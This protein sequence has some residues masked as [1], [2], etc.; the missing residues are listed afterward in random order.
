MATLFLRMLSSGL[1]A[2]LPV[3]AAVAWFA[4]QGRRDRTRAIWIG[5]AL[6]IVLTWPASSFFAASL[7]QGQWEAALA[8]VGAL[9]ALWVLLRPWAIPAIALVDIAIVVVVRQAIIPAGVL[10][11][12]L[13]M[14]ASAGTFQVLGAL[15]LSLGLAALWLV[16]ARTLP[17][18][19]L[20]TATAT[21]A[22]LFIAQT[23]FY[24]FHRAAEL[25][26]TPSASTLEALTEPYGPDGLYGP[27]I[28]ASIAA[29]AFIA[30]VLSAWRA[31]T[32]RRPVAVAAAAIVA[33][34]TAGIGAWRA[35]RPVPPPA[36]A[37]SADAAAN[38]AI[39]EILAAPH[40]LYRTSRVDANY[41]RL[42]ITALDAPG[43]RMVAS[44]LGCDRISFGGGAGICLHA[45]R[46]VTTTFEAILF[47]GALRKS[48]AIQVQGEPSRTRVSSDGRFGAFTVFLA[49]LPHGYTMTGFSTAT[50]IVNMATGDVLGNLESFT[51]F[52]DGRPFKA[53][54]FNFW[55]VTFARDSNTFYATLQTG[56]VIFLVRGDVSQKTLTVLREGIECP[57]LS[58][59]G[60]LIAFKQRLA[61]NPVQ[62]RLGVLDLSTMKDQPI[63]SETRSIDDQVEWLD[64]TH[65]LYAIERPGQ[66]IRDVWMAPIAGDAPA[67]L[68]LPEAESPIVVGASSASAV[69]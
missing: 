62:W 2:L 45:D 10:R 59:D 29:A 15:A 32:R 4:A 40:I 28:S 35:G 67:R 20:R 44:P 63:A 38:A 37:E 57:S 11:A 50:V 46:G 53:A 13:G 66:P 12:T 16:F 39:A 48:K 26:W 43:K 64:A 60:R 36:V 18:R 8:A 56:G 47:D 49:G 58:P 19:A 6:G 5:G 3:A 68:F 51:T 30:G 55:G 33:I 69:Q 17:A 14:P 31:G 7:R 9:A 54:D 41:G 52:R 25:G 1:Q 42:A 24:A 34:C 22:A 21:F 65:V 27:Y 23:A 61:S